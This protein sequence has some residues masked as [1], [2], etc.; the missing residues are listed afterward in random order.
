MH[1]KKFCHDQSYLDLNMIGAT[2]S[3]ER[4]IIKIIDKSQK[5]EF[6]GF[7]QYKKSPILSVENIHP[8]SLL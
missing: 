4:H 1:K 5:R 2:L 6:E 3:L 8:K 7:Y